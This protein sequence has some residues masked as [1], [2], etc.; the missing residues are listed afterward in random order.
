[1]LFIAPAFQTPMLARYRQF[2]MVVFDLTTLFEPILSLKANEQWNFEVRSSV[3]G[4]ILAQSKSDF[5]CADPDTCVERTVAA[6][7]D[8]WIVTMKAPQ[9]VG[10]SLMNWI[11]LGLVTI[12]MSGAILISLLVHGSVRRTNMTVDQRTNELRIARDDALRSA[13]AK[14]EF[15]ATMSHEIRTPLNGIIGMTSSL[16]ETNLDHEQKDAVMVLQDCSHSLLNL[17]NNILDMSKIEAG[18]IELSPVTFDLEK[19]MNSVYRI[20]HHI[21][22]STN[23]TL[24][25][26][27]D[28]AAHKAVTGDDGRL[29]QILIN[30]I[31]NALKFAAGASVTIAARTKDLGGQNIRLEIDVAD[32]GPGMTPAQLSRIFRPFS[33]ADAGITRRHGGTG[34]GLSI[35]QSLAKLMGGDITCESVPGKGTVFHISV[36]IKAN[37]GQKLDQSAE[38]T[39]TQFGAGV[40]VLVAEDN[41]TNQLVVR[42]ILEKFN[43]KPEFADHGQMAVSKAKA[44]AFDIIFMDLHMPE[45][46]GK[47]AATEIRQSGASQ[48]AWIVA[49]TADAFEQTRKECLAAGMNDFVTKPVTRD[50]ISLA[51]GKYTSNGTKKLA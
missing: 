22:K 47:A 51:L 48:A 33:Q 12:L 35:A 4:H 41:K 8:T 49:L 31:S 25:L 23:T 10:H 42:K 38:F 34:L 7:G 9:N 32:T 30:I 37:E 40:R 3:T 24:E 17:L 50:A 28:P 1:M 19:F 43:I 27:I 2:F 13:Q 46:D 26:A 15:L 29:R 39:P 6:G 21:A 20:F 11:I 36:N 45:L 14:S 5:R 16:A 44:Q 18:K